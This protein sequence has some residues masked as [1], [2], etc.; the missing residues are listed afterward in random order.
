MSMGRDAVTTLSA[1]VAALVLGTVQSVIL[2]RYLLPEGR[3]QYASLLII[4]QLLAVMA[5]LGLQW[6]SVYFLRVRKDATA[7]VLQNGLGLTL[8]FGL[9]G[10]IAAIVADFAT[11]DALL[12]GLSLTGIA[13]ATVLVPI[14]VGERFYHGALRGTDRIPM[15][16]LLSAA[17]PAMT[18]VGVLAVIVAIRAGVTGL[19]V[20]TVT[21]ELIMTLVAFRMI[22]R[23]IPPRPRLESSLVGPM[24]SYGLRIYSFSILL[25]LVYR[26][27]MALVRYFLDYEQVGY[28]ATS[29]TV[30]ELIW[31]VPSA[32]AFVLFPRIAGSSPETQ[33]RLTTA[34]TRITV[35]A[36][37]TAC[38]VAAALAWPA[39][40]VLYG[41]EF[42]PAVPPLV[43]LLPG[44][45]AMSVQQ[46][47][48]ADV[49]AR[50][51]PGRI[52]LAAGV[53]VVF[54]VGLNLW[55]IPLWGPTGAALA[56]SVAYALI[57]GLVLRSFLRLSGVSLRETLILR[58]Q[59]IADI[60]ERLVRLVRTRR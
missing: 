9:L 14:R 53:G 2:A 46:V 23:K 48:G 24:L 11:H 10:M 55:W 34:T 35:A 33:R 45:F 59:D 30:G 57:S 38:L 50:G 1:R 60:R 52:T 32:L 49:S 8:V 29:V 25:F 18:I 3:G 26:L 42:L 58:R 40:F 20:I 4:P 12:K 17:K 27:D 6:S 41:R 28:Y 36:V 21:A 16:N 15:I 5:P 39:I 56:S 43:C 54:N 47:L 31:N 44:I 13:I 22:F 37:G 7:R 19:I 51:F